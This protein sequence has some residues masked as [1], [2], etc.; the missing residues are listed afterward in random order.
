MSTTMPT[1]TRSDL[2]RH[3]RC[4]RRTLRLAVIGAAAIGC[5]SPK[6]A[7]K[8]GIDRVAGP[9]SGDPQ[10]LV[11]DVVSDS[12]STTEIRKSLKPL[13]AAR[14]ISLYSIEPPGFSEPDEDDTGPLT[15]EAGET[16]RGYAV[17]GRV[18]LSE[19]SKRT[20]VIRAIDDG[21]RKGDEPAL[22]FRPRHAIRVED[23]GKVVDY[24]ICFECW[25]IY[26][27]T[28]RQRTM[29]VTTSA[30]QKLLDRLLSDAGIP[31]ATKD[32]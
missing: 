2:L 13:A 29:E 14:I 20:A 21:I 22:C 19:D 28:G 23:D 18:D 4:L 5:G 31:L 26:V 25:Q 10:Q 27:C 30:P 3:I 1:P 17:L 15:R 6:D 7:G 9:T 12:P 8:S 24:I 16:L 11:T 32:E